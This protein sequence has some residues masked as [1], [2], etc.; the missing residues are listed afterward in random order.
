M[1]APQALADWPTTSFVPVPPTEGEGPD[2]T[3]A[4]GF[5]DYATGLGTIVNFSN[6]TVTVDTLDIGALRRG[7]AGA[8]TD[9][10]RL[11]SLDTSKMERAGFPAPKIQPLL[12]VESTGEAFYP[13][14][15]VAEL[16]APFRQNCYAMP[17]LTGYFGAAR[18]TITANGGRNGFPYSRINSAW[19]R[20]G[21]SKDQMLTYM[22]TQLVHEVMHAVQS[23]GFDSEGC[24]RAPKWLVEGTADAI[25]YYLASKRVPHAF[26]TYPW[27]RNT[28]RYDVSLDARQFTGATNLRYSY[29]AGSFFRYLIEATESGAASDLKIMKDLVTMPTSSVTSHN[30]VIDGINK[31]IK[32]NSGGRGLYRVLPEFLTEYGSYGGSRY[33]TQHYG[34]GREGDLTTENWLDEVFLHCVDYFVEPG[35][36][37]KKKITLMPLAGECVHVTWANFKEPVSLQFFADDAGADYGALH[38]GEAVKGN[39]FGKEYCY[40]VTKGLSNRLARK[41]TE[42]CILKRG[43]NELSGAG[44]PTKEVAAWTKD[45]PLL[46]TGEAYYIISNVA[47]EPTETKKLE[48]NLLIGSIKAE[49]QDGEHV[50]PREPGAAEKPVEMGMSDINKRVHAMNG[51]GDR[52]LFDGRSVFGD[53]V[54]LGFLE[55]VAGAGNTGDGVFTLVRGGDYWLGWIGAGP[56]QPNFG[57]GAF[58]LKDPSRIESGNMMRGIIMSAGMMGMSLD[59]D[60]GY[61]IIT[62]ITPIEETPERLRFRVE[63]D[64]FDTMRA[65]MAGGGEMPMCE[66]LRLGFVEHAVFEVALPYGA[67]YAGDSRIA[68]GHPPGQDVY[69]ESDFY[70]GPNFGGIETSRSLVVDGPPP[71]D[72]FNSPLPGG[73]GS[74]AGGGGSGGALAGNCDCSCRNVK[75]P[76]S[77]DCVAQCAPQ[78]AICQGGTSGAGMPGKTG[79][80][81]MPPIFGQAPAAQSPAQTAPASTASAPKAPTPTLEAQRKWFTRLISGQGLSPDVEK[82]LADDFVTMSDDTRAKL[83]RQYRDGVR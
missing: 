77:Q 6:D 47:K 11:V 65:M 29:A 13:I 3:I 21:R 39:A 35:D 10:M 46:G 30:G 83:I 63:A 52:I 75:D 1:A 5:G 2:D 23:N 55:G 4:S 8:L 43:A 72:M 24:G 49:K 41:M 42:K 44:S 50:K 31:V 18:W 76:P 15:W 81:G 80:P 56:N 53:G 62:V 25:A 57:D 7:A 70:N 64:L 36:V 71:D 60:C 59:E 16:N 69:D 54:G 34:G 45:F 14:F 79:I 48:I 28:R 19:R 74:A 38:L 51:A 37:V 58:I 22:S 27:M 33:R 40:D 61:D 78:W 66:V 26:D 9:V 73:G 68:R 20:G 82:M 32:A 12:V 17:G 67:L